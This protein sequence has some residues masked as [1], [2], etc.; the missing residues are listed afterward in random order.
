M[1]DGQLTRAII[2]KS[3]SE[4]TVYVNGTEAIYH[5]GGYSC[6]RSDVTDLCKAEG[7]NLL[8][9]ACSNIANDFVY[10]QNADFTFYGGL[11][12]GVNI[13]SVP[14]AHFDLE[15]YGGPGIM[16]TPKSCDCGHIF[17]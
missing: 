4:A 15:Y 3:S 17:W 14:N 5:E 6:F 13:I 2:P 8:V 1:K 10:P 7:E 11:Y 12:R 9:V 16:V